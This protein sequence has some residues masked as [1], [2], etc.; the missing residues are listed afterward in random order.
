MSEL[1]NLED[2]RRTLRLL[3]IA[4]LDANRMLFSGLQNPEVE[5][6]AEQR[7]TLNRILEHLTHTRE[8]FMVALRTSDL[9]L[10][11]ELHALIDYLI[12]WSWLDE[13][14]LRW[15]TD[16]PLERLGGQTILYQHALIALGVM[17]RLPRQAVTFP[18]GQHRGYTDVPV[19]TTP[20][21]TLNRLEELEN[22]IWAAASD[23]VGKLPP[24]AVRRTYGFF[25]AT[26]WLVA[27]HLRDV[28]GW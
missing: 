26:T 17:P 5:P 9:T 22:T 4:A 10:A 23:P 24:G 8:G 19:P 14:G 13:I 25:E 21:E 3:T 16:E 1:L 27:N 11:S 15:T 28:V 18:S 6:S 2:A 7:A 12:D 20:G